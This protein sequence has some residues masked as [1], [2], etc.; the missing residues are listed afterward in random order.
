[1]ELFVNVLFES[2][3][4]EKT[5]S[6]VMAGLESAELPSFEMCCQIGKAIEDYTE[7]TMYAKLLEQAPWMEHG[8]ELRYVCC[9][10]TPYKYVPLGAMEEDDLRERVDMKYYAGRIKDAVAR[11]L[12]PVRN[13]DPIVD[14][15]CK[16]HIDKKKRRKKKDE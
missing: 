7:T 10:D 13:T 6:A 3:D 16:D 14:Q 8:E 9:I 5:W 11:L 1:M 15:F 12:V 2:G 4:L